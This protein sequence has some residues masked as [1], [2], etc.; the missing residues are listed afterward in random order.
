[1]SVARFV[2][3]RTLRGEAVDQLA[4]PPSKSILSV[5]GTV[6]VEVR[7]S[8]RGPDSGIEVEQGRVQDRIVAPACVADDERAGGPVSQS[9]T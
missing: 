1:V 4:T 3:E 7:W 2:A 9:G 6:N 5:I 8:P